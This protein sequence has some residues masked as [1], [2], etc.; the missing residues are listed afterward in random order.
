[1]SA[2][3]ID[4]KA[5]AEEVRREVAAEVAEWVAAGNDPPGLATVLVGDDPASDIYI[6]NKHKAAREIGIEPF[7]HRLPRDASEEDVLGLV[8]E[9]NEND[10]IDAVLVQLP[11]P[12][13]ID[14]NQVIRAVAPIKDVD[15][16]HPF[17]AGQLYLGEPTHVPATPLGILALL[18]EYDVELE[19]AGA[20]VIGRSQIVGKPVAHLLLQRNATVTVCHSRTKDLADRARVADVLVV[21][22]GQAGLVSIDDVKPGA[23]VI[24][25][26][27]NRTDDGIV[28]D[29]DPAAA[30]RAGLITP[31]PGGVGPMT[32]AMLLSSTVR[33]ARYRR[34]LLAYPRG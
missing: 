30:E 34:G 10:E 29:V 22:T 3:I 24:D 28:G 9:L 6:R 18:D 32:I 25:V 21:A 1:M 13:G 12:D 15:G 4:G 27:I 23:T 31:V 7:D 26:G 8:D 2:E 14:E 16:F 5:V 19:G 17:N 11:L 20:V 33:A